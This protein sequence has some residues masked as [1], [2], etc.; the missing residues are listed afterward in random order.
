MI[1]AT[2]TAVFFINSY[3]H[4]R[5]QNS[6]QI[7]ATGKLSPAP[8]VINNISAILRY[9]EALRTPLTIV[10]TIAGAWFFIQCVAEVPSVPVAITAAASALA[11][12]F[13]PTTYSRKGGAR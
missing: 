7:K 1:V 3:N 6:I 9:A 12:G 13:I 10:A 5:M 8:A 4:S 2:V 11:A